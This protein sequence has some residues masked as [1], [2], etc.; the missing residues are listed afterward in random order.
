MSFVAKRLCKE[1]AMQH[2]KSF[3]EK[4]NQSGG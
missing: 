2:D 4:T 1:Q 3:V